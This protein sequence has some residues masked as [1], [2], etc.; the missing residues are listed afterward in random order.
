ML[1]PLCLNKFEN[2]YIANMNSIAIN[3]SYS[4]ELLKL[5]GIAKNASN[6]DD[7]NGDEARWEYLKE[8]YFLN[9]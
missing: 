6:I 9:E 7:L 8:R 2:L 5:V 4:S 3:T 1:C